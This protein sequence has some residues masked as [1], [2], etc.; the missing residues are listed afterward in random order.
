[1]SEANHFLVNHGLPIIMGVIFLEQMGVPIPALPW[2]MAAGALAATGKFQLGLGLLVSVLACLA[3]DFIWFYLGRYR[4]NKVLALLCRFSLEPDSCVS[5]TVNV[6]G[7]Y[8]WR[9]VVISKFVPGMSTVTP[10]LAGMSRM[11]AGQF[12][13][14]D[15][16]SSLLYCGLFLLLGYFF[17]NQIAQ[18]GAALA[19]I[20]GSTLRV[21]A[22]ILVLYVAY[23]YWQRQRLLTELR[24]AKITVNELRQMLDAIEKPF[25]LDLRS[26]MELEQDPHIILGAMHVPLDEVERRHKEFP[27]DR[28]IITYCDCPNEASSA[29]TA[30]RLRQ[31]GFTKVRPLL[32]GITAWREANHPMDAWTGRRAAAAGAPN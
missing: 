15:G 32:G 20:A 26:V 21:I 14:F 28:E 8:G 1:M 7:R 16:L 10:P 2:L 11:S 22:I 24:M 18:I 17:S 9:G 13:L 30:L 25:I 29:K 23:K 19:Q 12:L 6:F 5:R 4:G 3:A 27:R 31:R